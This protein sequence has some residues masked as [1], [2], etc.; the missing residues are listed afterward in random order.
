VSTSREL[1]NREAQRASVLI[2]SATMSRLTTYTVGPES[3]AVRFTKA[4]AIWSAWHRRPDGSSRAIHG[5]VGAVLGA[6]FGMLERQA[7]ITPP[8]SQPPAEHFTTDP[9]AIAY[10]R[11]VD[12]LAP[13]SAPE[14]GADA[15]EEVERSDQAAAEFERTAGQPAIMPRYAVM[16]VN[17]ADL[18]VGDRLQTRPDQFTN[19]VGRVELVDEAADTH[20]HVWLEGRTNL[21]AWMVLA[22]DSPV[23]IQRRVSA[24]RTAGQRP[25]AWDPTKGTLSRAA[26]ERRPLYDSKRDGSRVSVDHLGGGTFELARWDDYEETFVH[27]V[28]FNRQEAADACYELAAAISRTAD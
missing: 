6:L 13:A 2:E 12:E 27:V 22:E 20:V 28:T 16:S 11:A 24:E 9:E 15:F 26:S 21:A 8:L 4:G 10:E 5:G 17:A 19:T 14:R 18:Q 7:G 23:K 3:I 1:I 25:L